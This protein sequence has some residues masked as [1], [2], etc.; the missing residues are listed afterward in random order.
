VWEE[1]VFEAPD[2]IKGQ[3]GGSSGAFAG[4]GRCL[5]RNHFPISDC[6]MVFP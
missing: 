5:G 2:E 1:H 6:L 4:G 3:R